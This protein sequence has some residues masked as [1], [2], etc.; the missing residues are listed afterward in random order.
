MSPAL[1]ESIQDGSLIRGIIT[2]VVLVGAILVYIITRNIPEFLILALGTVLGYYFGKQNQVD[3]TARLNQV[4]R[5]VN[6]ASE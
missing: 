6:K 2:L 3:T 4:E 5:M 1:E